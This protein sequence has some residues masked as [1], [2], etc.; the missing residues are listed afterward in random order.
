M[1]TR[2]EIK[3]ILFYMKKS[4][5]NFTPDLERDEKR[6]DMPNS[7]DVFYDLLKH[8]PIDTLKLAV[9]SCCAQPGRAFAPSPGEIIGMVTSLHIKASGVPSAGEAWEEVIRTITDAGCHNG[10]PEFSHPLIKKAVQAI[11]FVNIGMSEDTMVE[12]AHFL[13][14]YGQYLARA[15]EDAAMLPEAAEYVEKKRMVDSET[16]G[17]TKRLES[18]AKEDDT[19]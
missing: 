10:T 2:D 15:S 11:G 5:P 14:I 9:R 8:L 7:V 19:R 18:K 1:A 16:A 4:F 3:I 17:L 12:R 6:P 13:K